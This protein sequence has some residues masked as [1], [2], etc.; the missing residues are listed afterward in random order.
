MQCFVDTFCR[1]MFFPV[2]DKVIEYDYPLVGWLDAL[3]H[4]GLFQG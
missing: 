4:K 1:E 2:T 3:C